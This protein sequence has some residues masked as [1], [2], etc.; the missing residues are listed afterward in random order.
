MRAEILVVDDERQLLM[1]VHET[2]ERK[3]YA[4]TTASNG[5]EAIKNCE[6]ATSS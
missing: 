4:V 6:K 5:M 3:G 1:A 2:L